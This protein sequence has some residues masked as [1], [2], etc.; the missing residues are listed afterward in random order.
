MIERL[1]I[2]TF[3]LLSFIPSKRLQVNHPGGR[4]LCFA[5]SR[6]AALLRGCPDGL[7][8]ISDF[9]ELQRLRKAPTE[10]YA[11]TVLILQRLDF[12]SASYCYG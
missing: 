12:P 5:P 6:P 10:D 4:G 7:H 1:E 9:P 8:C 3:V 11:Q 2:R